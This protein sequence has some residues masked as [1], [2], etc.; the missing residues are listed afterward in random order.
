MSNTS[1]H[2]DNKVNSMC[3]NDDNFTNKSN[4]LKYDIAVGNT[5]A[6]VDSLNCLFINVRSI[7][8]NFKIEELSD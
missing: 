6:V 7:L 5:R 3:A 4:K 2:S 8:N 1:E